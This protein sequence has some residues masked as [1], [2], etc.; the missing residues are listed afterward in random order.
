VTFN[1]TQNGGNLKETQA[2]KGGYNMS[3]KA[4]ANTTP[5]SRNP[6]NAGA[7]Q[8]FDC[9][10]TKTQGTTPWGYKSTFGAMTSIKGYYDS[11]RFGT[12]V[13]GSETRYPYKAKSI[14]A[15][16]M[17]ASSPLKTSAAGT[18]DGLCTP[19]HD[20]HGVTPTL[21][22]AKQQFA[23]PLLK[24]TW[25]SSPS[26]EDAADP[27]AGGGYY[28]KA[29]I[30]NINETDDK[31]AGLCLR[32]HLKPSLTD[33]TNKN[34]A[35]KGIDRVHESVKGWGANSRHAYACSKCHAPHVTGLPRLMVTNCL[36]YRH[37]GRVTSGGYA[38]SGSG[39]GQNQG[40]G[41]PQSGSG[42]FPLGQDQS[43]VNCH[44]GGTWPDNYWNE[45]T[46]WAK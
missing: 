34:T 7:G 3:Y 4:S 26:R 40:S 1:G 36:D 18:I 23:V 6:Y 15:G 12:G 43:G 20:P 35:W 39:S 14:K 30:E 21:G 25:M 13:N 42:S 38:G 27:N 5:G 31:F 44:P 46:P 24:G 10:L 11:D 2:G 37:R 45:V 17:K 28:N 8:C 33:G 9:H 19:C 41:G 16:H 29:N 32:C 22:A